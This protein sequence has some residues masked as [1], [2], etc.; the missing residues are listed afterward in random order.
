VL[1]PPSDYTVRKVIDRLA[2][3]VAKNGRQ[4]EH[5]TRQRNPGDTPFKFVS[6]SFL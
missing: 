5:I 6:F 1:S 2:N 4:H 3:L